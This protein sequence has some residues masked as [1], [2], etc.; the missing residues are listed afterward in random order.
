MDPRH[1][2]RI[3]F[4]RLCSGRFTRGMAVEHVRTGKPLTMART[5]Q[6]LGQE[7]TTVD[8]G[9]AGDI[10]G[11]W[12]GGN[13]RIG[14]TLGFVGNTGNARTTAPHLHFG[15]Y[16]RGGPIDPLRYVRQV[17]ATPRRIGS[18]TT[19]LGRRGEATAAVPLRQGPADSGQVVARIARRTAHSAASV[20]NSSAIALTPMVSTCMRRTTVSTFAM[21]TAT[22]YGSPVVSSMPSTTRHDT[23]LSPCEWTV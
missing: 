9:Y 21:L 4:V 5:V 13:L 6:F 23:V 1:R 3:A 22:A 10:L 17:T 7:R 14:D 11:V 16:T 19:L 2:D 18:D 12:D 8:E 15:I 20:A